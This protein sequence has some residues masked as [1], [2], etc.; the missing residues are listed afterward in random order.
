MD[1]RTNTDITFLAC[2]KHI[3]QFHLVL[4]N[5]DVILA[6]LESW[7]AYCH[8]SETRFRIW[9]QNRTLWTLWSPHI[10]GPWKRSIPMSPIKAEMLLWEATRGNNT[11]GPMVIR[12]RKQTLFEW[13]D[14]SL[15][16]SQTYPGPGAHPL[17]CLALLT[18]QLKAWNSQAIH[19]TY[20]N[21]VSCRFLL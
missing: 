6:W 5:E 8:S 16:Q 2:R 17:H 12:Y 1:N 20:Y 7:Q 15:I 14:H 10:S 18:D 9:T 3:A 11:F 21:L 19:H 13:W 4:A